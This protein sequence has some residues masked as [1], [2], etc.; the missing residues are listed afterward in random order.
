MATLHETPPEL[1]ATTRAQRG[2]VPPRFQ[3]V[4]QAFALI[5]VAC[6]VTLSMLC[7]VVYNAAKNGHVGDV[8]RYFGFGVTVAALFSIWAHGRGLYSKSLQHHVRFQIQA[9]TFAWT[10]VFLFLVMVG[11]VMKIGDVVPEGPV[12]LIFVTG[13]GGMAILRWGAERVLLY[14]TRSGALARRQIVVVAQSGRP[15]S[16]NLY[17]AIED[18][19][20]SIC[21]TFWLPVMPSA[22]VLSESMRKLIDYVR[23]RQVDE[24]LLATRWADTTLIDKITEHLRVVPVPVKLA[25]DPIVSA[26]L[27]RPLVEFGDAKAV[28]L[29]RAPLTRPQLAAKRLLDLVLVVLV[30]PLMLLVLAVVAAII[31]LDSPGPVLFRQ[32][33]TGFNGRLFQIYKF[34]TM[35]TLEDG[36]FIQQ[37]G[38]DDMRVTRV[39]RVLRRLS[40]DELPQLFNV[41]KGEMSLV[42]PRPHALAHDNQYGRF[43]ALYAARHNVRPGITGWAQV[44]DWRG[45]TPQIHMMISRIEHD[46]WYINHWSLWLDIKI[47]ILTI[48]RVSRLKNA[49]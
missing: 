12:L 16:N 5:D 4:P 2:Y 35:K 15:V 1:A 30:L 20:G 11:L 28:E 39:G 43:I 49:Y 22:G 23:R 29:R 45:P 40:I 48:L 46:L 17:R 3:L 6:I 31:L 42:G 24:I 19:G 7:G 26:L 34:R 27:Y 9:M 10:M 38:Q 21:E 14:L 44:N 33:R 47:L 36:E 13:L 32:H 41:L 37:A 8:G 25:P 18:T